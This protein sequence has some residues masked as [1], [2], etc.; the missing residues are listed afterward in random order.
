MI[1]KKLNCYIFKANQTKTTKEKNI[2]NNRKSSSRLFYLYGHVWHN[3]DF[4][5]AALAV[6]F[7]FF[8]LQNL[9]TK[10][11]KCVLGVLFLL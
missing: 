4:L 10:H 11:Y 2:N 8:P 9:S 5:T 7:F 3:N 6:N 1:Y